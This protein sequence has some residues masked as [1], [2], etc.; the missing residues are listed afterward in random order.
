MPDIKDSFVTEEAVLP[1][2][3]AKV[4]YKKSLKLRERFVLEKI[5]DES[6]RGIQT[7]LTMLV[8]WDFTQEGQ[9][10]VIDRDT[11]QELPDTDIIYLM[12]L[13]KN[14]AKSDSG[15]DNDQKKSSDSTSVIP[16]TETTPQPTESPVTS[17]PIS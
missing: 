1:V 3:G 15:V 6:E 7:L 10:M 9:P 13:I 11:V 12:S 16:S 14:A 17:I 8:G 4:H 5:E 2:S